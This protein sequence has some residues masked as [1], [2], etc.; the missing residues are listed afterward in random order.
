MLHNSV[1]YIRLCLVTTIDHSEETKVYERVHENHI[2][3]FCL[4]NL[5]CD[6]VAI[7]PEQ[8]QNLLNTVHFI[9]YINK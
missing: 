2:R 6:S 4:D 7:G 3:K 1:V 8:S 9:L 5:Q